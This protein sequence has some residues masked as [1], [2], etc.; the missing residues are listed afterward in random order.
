MSRRLVSVLLVAGVIG[1]GVFLATDAGHAGATADFALT[2]DGWTMTL[3]DPGMSQRA[4]YRLTGPDTIESFAV[5]RATTPLETLSD[6]G[7]W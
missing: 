3:L 2:A 1:L 4:T 6:G 5:I 7:L